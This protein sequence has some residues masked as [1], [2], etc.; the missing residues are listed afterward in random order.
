[1]FFVVLCCYSTVSLLNLDSAPEAMARPSCN[2]VSCYLEFFCETVT[3]AL[4]C[5]TQSA[6]LVSDTI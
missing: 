6:V 2:S 1:M 3:S 5:F 4:K